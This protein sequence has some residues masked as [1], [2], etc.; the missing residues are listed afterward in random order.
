M[1]APQPD[2]QTISFPSFSR[3]DSPH[4]GHLLFKITP[5]LLDELDDMDYVVKQTILHSLELKAKTTQCTDCNNEYKRLEEILGRD[6]SD[7]IAAK[8]IAGHL[9]VTEEDFVGAETIFRDVLLLRSRSLGADH[10]ETI[11]T[12]ISLMDTVMAR[13]KYNE[14]KEIGESIWETMTR[15]KTSGANDTIK[16]FMRIPDLASQE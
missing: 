10:P 2:I 11:K 4:V 14:A 8:Y 7:S 9:K 12:V 16:Y 5:R 13:D 6:H 15:R 3:L 1:R